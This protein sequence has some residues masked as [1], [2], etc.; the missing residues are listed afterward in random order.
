M[1]A[2]LTQVGLDKLLLYLLSLPLEVAVVVPHVTAVQMQAG[3]QQRILR[4]LVELVA[5]GAVPHFQVLVVV[6]A[7]R[8]AL[9]LPV[10]W[11]VQVWP[12]TIP[13]APS[14][15]ALVVQVESLSLA[16]MEEMQVQQ[17][18]LTQAQVEVV[19]HQ[20]VQLQTSWV[21]LVVQD[22][23]WFASLTATR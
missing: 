19:V 20:E 11:V 10:P 1:Q 22:L 4:P 6:A 14:R 21:V 17:A 23:F 15:M 12:T 9:Q 18:L 7:I 3:L 8:L 2:A 13:A 16:Q 5:L